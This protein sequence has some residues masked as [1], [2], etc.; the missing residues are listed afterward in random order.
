ME[1]EQFIVNEINPEGTLRKRFSIYFSNSVR[2][3]SV[4]IFEPFSA[5]FKDRS[6]LGN[7]F[8]LK[9]SDQSLG[10]PDFQQVFCDNNGVI[11]YRCEVWETSFMVEGLTCVKVL[12]KANIS[13]LS[14]CN[15]EF[16][17]QLI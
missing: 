12:K 5:D 7:F 13:L 3:C 14:Y 16:Y 9:L 11:Q 15:D 17:L 10:F 4:V 6:H 2:R 8:K 1:I